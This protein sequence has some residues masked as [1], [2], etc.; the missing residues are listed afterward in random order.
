MGLLH[1]NKYLIVHKQAFH[2]LLEP[3]SY[4]VR[5]LLLVEC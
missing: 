3:A 4:I 5:Q 2:M 1:K